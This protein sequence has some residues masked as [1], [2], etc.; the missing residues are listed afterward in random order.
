V[1]ETGEQREDDSPQKGYEN[2]NSSN[3][4]NNQAVEDQNEET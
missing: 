1:N 4:N 2:G 3:N